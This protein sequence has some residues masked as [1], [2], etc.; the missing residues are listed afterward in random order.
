LLKDTALDQSM[1][2]TPLWPLWES[3]ERGRQP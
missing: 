1:R 3:G 2:G